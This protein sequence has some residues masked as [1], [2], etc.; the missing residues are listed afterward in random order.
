MKIDISGKIGSNKGLLEVRD[1]MCLIQNSPIQLDII[2][3]LQTDPNN[4][5]PGGLFFLSESLDFFSGML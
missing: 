4:V 5:Q 2:F 3:D 1:T